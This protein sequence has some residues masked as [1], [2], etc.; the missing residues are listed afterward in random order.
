[1]GRNT[2]SNRGDAQLKVVTP[3]KKPSIK[4]TVKRVLEKGPDSGDEDDSAYSRILNKVQA[5]RIKRGVKSPSVYKKKINQ[6][7]PTKKLPENDNL[8]IEKVIFN[9][10]NNIMEM[11]VGEQ[12]N[13]EF[14]SDMEEEE[15]VDQQGNNNATR[16]V[17]DRTFCNLSS[18]G[19]ARAVD[20]RGN[21]LEKL[22]AFS[23]DGPSTTSGVR[24]SSG[25]NQELTRTLSVMQSYFIKRG[26]LNSSMSQQ[27]MQK[28]IEEEF[29]NEEYAD[30]EVV[31]ATHRT[32]SVPKKVKSVK[33]TNQRPK[34]KQ[35]R[36]KGKTDHIQGSQSPSNSEVTIFKRAVKQIAP[37]LEREIDNFI[38]EARTATVQEGVLGGDGSSSRK[39]SSSSD[40]LMD[41]SEENE[42]ANG[43]VPFT[44]I[45]FF[46]E[47]DEQP[48]NIAQ[49]KADDLIRESQ[50]S[51]ARVFEVSGRD[52][53]NTT[54]NE[55][56]IMDNNY[57]M[58]DTHIDDVLKRKIINFEYVD[59]GKLLIRNRAFREDDQKL[60]IVS[61]NGMTFL[62]PVAD[63]DNMQI[64]SFGRW[65]QAFCVFANII[66]TRYPAKAPELLQYSY[67]IHMASTSYV[68]DNV[69]SY[70]KEFRRHIS[71]FP[72]RSWNVILQQVWTMLL[73]DRLK[74]DGGA[75]HKGGP[76]STGKGKREPCRRYN[77]GKCT[78]GLSC[79]YDHRCSVLKCGKFGHGAHICRMR[80]D[81]K[82]DRSQPGNADK[83]GRQQKS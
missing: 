6:E 82:R 78:F 4:S 7:G 18:Q 17:E 56:A 67:T 74:G 63:R 43:S 47:P 5:S 9:E 59:F 65:E 80:E 2:R 76:P 66:T 77:K 62:S 3:K 36:D 8:V 51:Q 79:N 14:P 33:A 20:A 31:L 35:E 11:E 50:Q 28:M 39:V 57:Q 49:Q 61:R 38:A 55:I 52:T 37:G 26:I 75:S 19:S 22:P 34:E 27:E 45:R 21:G 53:L 70:D 69:Y 72:M 1:M 10:D 42:L 58:L 48:E 54:I 32:P 83:S 46:A 41:T 68:W 13:N 24:A 23:D 30:P 29:G 81:N 40:E 60:E 25:G 16:A 64:T 71:R 44:N 12:Q 73:K 15:N